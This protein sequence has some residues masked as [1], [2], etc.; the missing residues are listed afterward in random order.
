MQGAGGGRVGQGQGGRVGIFRQGREFRNRGLDAQIRGEGLGV[1]LPLGEPEAQRV[2]VGLQNGMQVGGEFGAG[3]FLHAAAHPRP[4]RLKITAPSS[5]ATHRCLE[6][7]RGA[8]VT[9]R[10]RVVVREPVPSVVTAQ[11]WF[12]LRWLSTETMTSP[13]PLY[14]KPN[15]DFDQRIETQMKYFI[16]L[17]L[18]IVCAAHVLAADSKIIAPGATLQKLAGGFRLHRGA[19]LRRRGQCVLHRPAQRPHS[20]MER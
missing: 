11:D 3:G 6:S 9:S 15:L 14:T 18:T 16:Q 20:E 4:T 10:A 13:F 1:I 5:G 8:R 17:F 2:D 12:P 19:G 7:T